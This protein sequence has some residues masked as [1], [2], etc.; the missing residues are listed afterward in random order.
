M[1]LD[2]EMPIVLFRWI[3]A[4]FYACIKKDVS[5]DE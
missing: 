4:F 5:F 2:K 3:R 1:N